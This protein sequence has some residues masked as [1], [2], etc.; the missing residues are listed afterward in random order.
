MRSF[1]VVGGL[2][3]CVARVR[4]FA[5]DH[6]VQESG[7][8]EYKD[9]VK[10]AQVREIRRALA[11]RSSAP[12][13]FLLTGEITLPAQNALLKS[14]EELPSDAYFFICVARFDQLIETILS[15]A[16]VI[17]VAGKDIHFGEYPDVFESD[18]SFVFSLSQ[19]YSKGDSDDTEFFFY[20]S[21]VLRGGRNA[22]FTSFLDTYFELL[23]LVRN[24][25]VNRRMMFE[26][27]LMQSRMAGLTKDF[28][29]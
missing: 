22:S 11:V 3:E 7:F 15:R 13:L 25:N 24:N 26:A 5:R 6:D 27:L 16:S 18:L 28:K 9:K 29:M 1:V 19:I 20:A 21:K 10:I 17:R 12:R 4:E 14:I 2:E 8:I 23:P